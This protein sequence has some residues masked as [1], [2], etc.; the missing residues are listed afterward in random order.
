MQSVCALILAGGQGT[1][2]SILAEH[3]AKPAVPFGGIYRIVDFTLSNVMHSGI[4]RVGILTQYRPFALMSHVGNGADWDLNG[5]YRTARIL[6]PFTGD[7][8]NDWYKGTADAVYQN[9]DFVRKSNPDEVLIV[10]GDHIY[11]MDFRE[12]VQFHRD[13]QAEVTV[14]TLEVPLSEASRF[15]ILAT[16]S[17]GRVTHFVEKPKNPPSNQASMGI[18]LFRRELLEQRLRASV[19]SGGYDFGK[20]IFPAL[21][22]QNCVFAYPFRG[23]WRDVGTI[24]SYWQA[25]MDIIEPESGLDL[26]N[27]R[28]RTNLRYANVA[29]RPPARF[30]SSARVEASMVGRGALIEGEV[31]RSILGPGVHVAKGAVVSD[32]I[33]LHDVRVGE[34]SRV[35]RSIVDKWATIGCNT[36]I[37]VG[38]PR[39]NEE[40][41]QLLSCN[42]NVIGEYA[43][44]ADNCQIGTNVFIYPSTGVPTNEVLASG[45]T[46]R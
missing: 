23:Y 21:V 24:E 39:P 8:D 5:I 17:D 16:D 3:R 2:L 45:R 25:H 6:P 44:I 33:V 32:S 29:A 11:S 18:Y 10:S 26:G 28:V 30:T 4:A 13:R 37:G 22:D 27:W 43:T 31:R 38:E 12:M 20:D 46:W 14:A 42:L 9:L 1:R 34:G 41:P 36:Q 19:K 15:G 40:A 7:V 35:S